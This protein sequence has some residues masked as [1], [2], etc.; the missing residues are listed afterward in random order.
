[1]TYKTSKIP[2]ISDIRHHNFSCS[3]RIRFHLNFI[4]ISSGCGT[5]DPP[6]GACIPDDP[7]TYGYQIVDLVR[8]PQENEN[9]DHK[10]KLSPAGMVPKASFFL[11]CIDSSCFL[12]L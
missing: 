3:T 10:N 8:F 7:M 5:C 12:S 6:G 1:M 9:K 2:N 11:N 4:T